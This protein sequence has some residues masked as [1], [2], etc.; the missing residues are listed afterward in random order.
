ME[1][2]EID[3][4]LANFR[5]PEQLIT[6]ASLWGIVDDPVI[7]LRLIELRCQ[8]I[9]DNETRSIIDDHEANIQ[10]GCGSDDQ[11]PGPSRQI[12]DVFSTN[13]GL[14]GENS[15]YNIRKKGERVFASNH[16]R[17]ITFEIRI[18]NNEGRLLSS[19]IEELHRMFTSVLQTVRGSLAGNDSAR[20][21]IHHQALNNPIVIPLQPWDNLNADS[22][23][24]QIQKVLNS[25]ETLQIDSSFEINIGMIRMPKG[26]RKRGLTD[27]HGE[28]NSLH[29]KRSVIF[30]T[31]EDNLCMARAISVVFAKLNQC[32]KEQ[33]DILKDQNPEKSNLELGLEHRKFS[34]SYYK[35]LLNKKRAEQGE[36]ARELCRRAGLP[37]DR[38]A[39]I[40]DLPAFE[41][42]L[43]IKIL[44]VS[45]RAGNK[46]LTSPD[47]SQRPCVYLYLVDD[48]H[49]HAISSITG[50]FGSNY[51]CQQC[52]KHYDHR[53]LH[54]CDTHCKSCLSDACPV[55][56]TL[57]TCKNCK[58]T[59]RSHNC[60][61]RHKVQ[62]TFLKGKKKGEV[63]GPSMCEKFWKCTVCYKTINVEHRDKTNH[64]CGEYV[65]SSCK[66]FVLEGHLCYIRTTPTKELD[67][68]QFI[69]FDFECSQDE[70]IE[71]EQG[72]LPI[73]RLGCESCK[74][75]DLCKTCRDCV[76]CHK[77]Q[78][79]LYEHRPNFVVAH[80]VCP[81]CIEKPLTPKA[82]CHK[83]GSR[84]DVCADNEDEPPCKSTCGRREIVFSG[85]N[86]C[87]TFCKWLFNPRYRYFKAVAHNMRSYD[88]FF[89]LN[90]LINQSIRPNKIIFSGSKIMY[91]EVGRDLH[92]RVLDSLN[93]LP[94]KLS[95]L[96]IS[97]GL[98][99]LKKGW[100]PHFFNTR[101]NQE[102]IGPYPSSHY[103]GVDYMGAKEREAFLDWHGGLQGQIF[104]FRREILEYC[105]SDVD[106]LRKAC[107]KFRNLLRK[108]TGRYEEV[109][110]AKGTVEQ[111]IVEAI[112]PFDYITIAS[113]CMGVFRTKFMEETW[114]VKLDGYDEWKPAKLRDGTLSIMMDGQWVSE[115]DLT[116]RTVAAKEFIEMSS[117]VFQFDMVCTVGVSSVIS[118]GHYRGPQSRPL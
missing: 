95:Q 90:Y 91:M 51:F 67:L 17:E 78:C 32:S 44:V 92:I 102:Y 105:R 4:L 50:L 34:T 5:D 38:P 54:T 60:F 115:G 94:M 16:V 61:L 97:F 33:W 40:N 80:T 56:D 118:Q 2:G 1:H 104:D 41:Q 81:K 24:E 28:K 55:T 8:Q 114:K 46:F 11:L 49:F 21:V 63:S 48:C 96:P 87:E 106:I 69:F 3:E 7:Q 10:S 76:H 43:D 98:A 99:E 111:Q 66:N 65:C 19:F 59:F 42:L 35:N 112:D 9:L 84:C 113:V 110:N 79:G 45:A 39:S 117:F 83:C 18:N 29:L 64:R 74:P 30:I 62:P 107:L 27:L 70:K 31:N 52:L 6:W 68:P 25:N 77:A 23:L 108:A 20:V 109:V 88:G 58:V 72:Y 93:F 12:D 14:V 57:L 82:I 85:N 15:F 100:F 75:S 73:R 101:E 36:M 86:T 116:K 37:V 13:P 103:Y 53:E 89:L 22:I 71:C 47:N 26:G